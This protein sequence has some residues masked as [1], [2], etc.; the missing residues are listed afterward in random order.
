MLLKIKDYI[1]FVLYLLSKSNNIDSKK[2]YKHL[3]NIMLEYYEFD[4]IKE[5]V[6]LLCLF[7]QATKY[8]GS[9]TYVILSFIYPVLEKIK[10]KIYI[11][12]SNIEL[13]DFN[14]KS[15]I[16]NFYDFF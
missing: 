9:K 10:S 6:E 16:F 3:K 2:D 5:I 14:I 15:N 12:S 1:E 7:A 8:L 13:V 11:L 4:Y